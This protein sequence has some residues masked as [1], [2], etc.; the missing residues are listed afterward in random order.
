MIYYIT[1]EEGNVVAK[2]D[3][4]PRDPLQGH[5]QHQVETLDE[6]PPVDQWDKRYITF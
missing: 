5:Q 2:F 4:H 1:D 6:L 3:G